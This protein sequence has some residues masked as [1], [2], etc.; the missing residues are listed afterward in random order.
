MS[1][2]D[3][4]LVSRTR[5]N[6]IITAPFLRE[7]QSELSQDPIALIVNKWDIPETPFPASGLIVV[8]IDWWKKNRWR[9]FGYKLRKVDW[10]VRYGKK[11]SK[12]TNAAYL[13][14][15]EQRIL[16]PQALAFVIGETTPPQRITSDRIRNLRAAMRSKVAECRRFINRIFKQER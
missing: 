2:D 16:T 15:P 9:F 11:I 8:R 12:L 5:L 14:D 13:C 4:L 6:S 7:L 10:I 3:Q 1:F